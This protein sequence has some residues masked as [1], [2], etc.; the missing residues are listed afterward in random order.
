MATHGDEAA[1]AMAGGET[2]AAGGHPAD[3]SQHGGSETVH[4]DE[5]EASD[6]APLGSDVKS[7]LPGVLSMMAKTQ[8]DLVTQRTGGAPKE[9]H[10]RNLANIKIEEICGEKGTSAYAYRQWKKSVE[11]TKRLHALGDHELAMIMYTQ[12][13]GMAKKRVEI[14]ELQDLERDD[15]LQAMLADF[16]PEL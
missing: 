1:A 9:E 12:L 16:G 5:E 13:K 8:R 3:A 11:V 4:S 2:A 15:I 14:L 6:A 10:K 7:W